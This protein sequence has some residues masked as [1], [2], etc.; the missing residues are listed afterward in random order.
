MSYFAIMQYL[1]ISRI[2]SRT[3]IHNLGPRK[4]VPWQKTSLKRTLLYCDCCQLYFNIYLLSHITSR[5]TSLQF[6]PCPIFA[7]IYRYCKVWLGNSHDIAKYVWGSKLYIYLFISKYYAI[8]C[9]FMWSLKL[10]P[11]SSSSYSQLAPQT[12]DI[13]SGSQFKYDGQDPTSLY[14]LHSLQHWWLH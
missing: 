5:T 12:P 2:T 9:S 10:L 14:W 1:S 3:T 7:N 11:A 4:W 13:P 8:I 6:I